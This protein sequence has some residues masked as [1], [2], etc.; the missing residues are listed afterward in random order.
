[1]RLMPTTVNRVDAGAV[2]LWPTDPYGQVQ[3]VK[4]I[5]PSK[6]MPG[7]TTVIAVCSRPKGEFVVPNDCTVLI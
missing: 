5:G 1:M 2:V 4:V 6:T 3:A 7:Y